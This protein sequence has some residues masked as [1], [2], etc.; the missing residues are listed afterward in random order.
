MSSTLPS[1]YVWHNVHACRA[2]S[3]ACM[4]HVNV[5]PASHAHNTR[6]QSCTSSKYT[7]LNVRAHGCYPGRVQN[8]FSFAAH[9]DHQRLSTDRTIF[10]CCTLCTCVTHQVLRSRSYRRYYR[11]IKIKVQVPSFLMDFG[12]QWLEISVLKFSAF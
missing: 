11:G 1:G 9:L 2:S 10:R 3:A 12:D 8:D 4:Q 5:K 7:C 6:P